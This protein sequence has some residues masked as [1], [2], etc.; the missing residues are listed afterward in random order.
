L[1]TIDRDGKVSRPAQGAAN[2]LPICMGY[3]D[4]FGNVLGGTGNFSVSKDLSSG[5]TE[6]TISGETYSNT[7]YVTLVTAVKTTTQKNFCMTEAVSGKLRVWQYT[8]GGTVSNRD[9]H[10]VIYKLN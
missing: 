7:G 6:I 4:V 5:L 10:F 1:V 9:F 3:V 8:D 2:L